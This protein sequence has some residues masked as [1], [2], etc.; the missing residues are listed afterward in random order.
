MTPKTKHIISE[1]LYALLGIAFTTGF[2][3]SILFELSK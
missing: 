3:V 1:T 2:A